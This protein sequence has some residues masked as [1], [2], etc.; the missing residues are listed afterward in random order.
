MLNQIL[1]EK[2]IAD[3]IIANKYMEQNKMGFLQSLFTIFWSLWNHRN[4]VLHQGK[5]PNLMEVILTLQTLICRY[6]EA[7]NENQVQGQ[8]SRN[9]PQQITHNDWQ[10]YSLKWQAIRKEAPREAVMPMKPK[11]WMGA[12]SQVVLAIEG[13]FTLLL[14][15]ML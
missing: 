10:I 5:T 3:C 4:Q 9:H 1:V 7:F 15:R 11:L 8:A 12:P 6:L 13:D 14:S 2:W